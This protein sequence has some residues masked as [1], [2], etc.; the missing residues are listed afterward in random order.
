MDLQ[1][2][3][4]ELEGV[5]LAREGSP[6]GDG[7]EQV[8]QSL[9]LSLPHLF[10]GAAPQ[11]RVRIADEDPPVAEEGKLPH[12]QDAFPGEGLVQGV[13]VQ[14]HPH[15]PHGVPPIQE[16]YRQGGHQAGLPGHI[17]VGVGF[18]HR[19]PRSLESLPVPGSL[20]RIGQ[21]GLGG[22]EGAADR[23]V[24]SG[25][26]ALEAALFPEA[27]GAGVGRVPPVE[28]VGLRDHPGGQGSRRGLQG[29]PHPAQRRAP[30][31][32]SGTIHPLQGPGQ[33]SDRGEGLPEV[34]LQPGRRRIRGPPG[35]GSG[36]LPGRVSRLVG[37]PHR[38]DTAD[39]KK[40]PQNAHKQSLL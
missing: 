11:L 3:L 5:V 15:Q 26:G 35:D 13:Q 16:G 36:V 28:G 2:V 22:V 29:L 8:V 6:L 7:G 1:G 37:D 38:A 40:A 33:G 10:Q 31:A 39:Q 4:P 27:L 9:D 14:V 19:L 17:G 21:H 23:P 12:S 30:G 32:R 18:L 24:Q 34:P 20:D 25:E